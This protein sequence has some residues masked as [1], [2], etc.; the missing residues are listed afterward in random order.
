M[1]SVPKNKMNCGFQVYAL[2][3]LEGLNAAT[4]GRLSH[5]SELAR[6]LLRFLPTDEGYN[7][8]CSLGF[9]HLLAQHKRLGEGTTRNKEV[10]L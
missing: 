7:P 1:R 9:L 4:A 3:T 5:S 8:S 6:H 2:G 10:Q